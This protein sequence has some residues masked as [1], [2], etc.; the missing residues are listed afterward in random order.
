MDLLKIIEDLPLTG[1]GAK[2]SIEEARVRR[3]KLMI[4]VL[5]RL[6]PPYMWLSEL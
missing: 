1:N 2:M 6:Y 5:A 4:A 3:R